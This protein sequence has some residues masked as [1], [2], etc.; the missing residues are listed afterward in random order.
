MLSTPC[1]LRLPSPGCV[2]LG[3]RLQV[4]AG[5]TLSRG[6]SHQTVLFPL[7]IILDVL[8]D[9]LMFCMHFLSTSHHAASAVA[10]PSSNPPAS[11]API[12]VDPSAF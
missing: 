4:G 5:C 9:H 7:F 12:P 10:F 8:V 2:A 6:Q 11:S 1:L 3:E